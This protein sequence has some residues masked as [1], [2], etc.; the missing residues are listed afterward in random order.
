MKINN[1]LKNKR[2][3]Y[4]FSML[5]L[6]KQLI[7][8]G[9]LLAEINA[10]AGSKDLK[11][12]TLVSI[13]PTDSST[14][15]KTQRTVS[16]TVLDESGQPLIGASVKIKGESGGTT[17]NV[18]GKFSI[19]VGDNAILVVSYIG[20]DAKEVPVGTQTTLSI[21]LA[22]NAN[23]LD[24][25]VVTSLGIKREQKSLGYAVSTVTSKQLTEA[26]N[27]NFASALY[28]KAAGVKI[29]TA[30]G[31]ASGA[32]NVQIRGIN[33]LAYNQQPLYVVDGVMIRNDNQNGAAGANNN[34]YW[35]DQRIRGNGILDINPADIESL[36]VLKGASATAL[37]GSDAASGVIVI[38]TKKGIKG[39]GLGIDFN[40]NGTIENVAFLPKFQNTYGPGYDKATNVA[41]GATEE[42]WIPDATSPSGLRP[43]FRAYAQF[44]PRME[45][46]QVKWW[47]GSI[48][49]YSAQPDNYKNVYQTGYSSN[50]NIALSNQTDKFNYRLSANRMD[51]KGTQPGS[52][53]QR[54][55]FNLNSTV[56]LSDKLTAD[57]IVNYVN[58][59]THNRPYQL[60]QVLGS[61][62]GYFS[63]AED[64]SLMKEK[65]QTSA[66]YKYVTFDQPARSP[67]AFIYNIR[68]TNL[69]DFYWQ[70]LKNSY[71]ET[72]NRLLTSATL[73]YDIVNH[74]KFRGRIGNDYTG[75]SGENLQYNDYPVAFNSSSSS[76]GSYTT[77]KGLY[78]ILYG[79]ALLTY[80]NKIGSD[81]DLSAS[82][83]YQGRT[84]NFKDQS[85]GTS[86]GL[87]SANW[88]SLNN[89]YGILNTSSTRKELLKYAFLGILNFSYKNYLF[90]EGT[91]RQEY[92]SSL[93]SE[94]NT[95][96]YPSVNTSFVFSDA[97]KLPEAFSFGKI[98][99]SYGIVGNAP[100]LY[101]ANILYNQTS[102]QTANGSVPQLT[103]GGQYGNNDLQPEKKYEAEFGFETRFLDNRIGL[104]VSYY[105]NKIK[106]QILGLQTPSSI[107][108]TSQIVNVGEIGSTGL[109]IALTA[110]PIRGD[111]RWDT[112]FN[113]AFN[114]TKV[115]DL[116]PG[117][118]QLTFY[119]AEQSTV[120]IVAGVGEQLGNIYVNP[121]LTDANG[122]FVINDDGLYIMD[123]NNYVKAGNI[124]PKA[125]GGFSNT[126]A[127]KNISLD[128]TIDYRIGGQMVSA[129]TKY[130]MGAGMFENTMQYRDA[131]NGGL[132]YTLNG[133]NYNDGVLLQ[134][135]N[136]T[137]GAPNDKIIDA[138]TYYMNTFN[139]GND[140]WSEEGSI[141]DN[142]YIKMREM[143]LGYNLPKSFSSKLS[144]NNLKVSLIGRNLFY[145]WKTLEN[146]DPE[147]PLGN[148]WWSQGVDVGSTAPTRS[149]GFS[150]N[151]NF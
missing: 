30:P 68:A 131:A 109:E 85:S 16:G 124:M 129:P 75:V 93:P 27:T 12:L 151:A 3:S 55:S 7:I 150:I 147:A 96:F 118:S 69:L 116:L 117:V 125:V 31:G 29:T 126:F 13:L 1:Y 140:S 21:S 41:N 104:D 137:T 64:M 20:Y 103:F 10:V 23:T 122:N 73:T 40:Y 92:A 56:K 113:L 24:A 11:A 54:N 108:A 112:R 38:T 97:F 67:E 45:G 61:F 8:T 133:K 94:N 58:T 62:G 39:R 143:T 78:S 72:E 130:L 26:G 105:T 17:T 42:G 141:F 32:V 149:F 19:A 101:E 91:A 106:N 9:I 98:R 145:I 121:R 35:D 53:Q 36:S 89:S 33:S 48:R 110:S 86:A 95:Y 14:T 128:F 138:A 87:V 102:L 88:F 50:A 83:G 119:E 107:G 51:Y 15:N 142:S 70:Q 123:K 80:A 135:V 22:P 5:R 43:Y 18:A 34:N 76:T 65:F 60:G 49:S 25:V 47:D 57:V 100:P 99:A 139:W 59:L 37:Y 52:K 46:Q 114:K 4:S 84:E 134:G 90:V 74:L 115:Y 81:F 144:L 6:S 2:H 120:K 66:G 148:K 63:R 136:Q 82:A 111:F 28:G 127:Y 79:D 146:L 132:A 44:G 71:D 77:T